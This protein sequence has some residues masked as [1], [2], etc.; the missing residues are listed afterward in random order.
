MMDQ[1]RRLPS[2][3]RRPHPQ[4]PTFLV[5]E[6]PVWWQPALTAAAGGR[7][8][9]TQQNISKN[10]CWVTIWM[11]GFLHLNHISLWVKTAPVTW[12]FHISTSLCESSVI[13]PTKPSPSW[14]QHKG[15]S[16]PRHHRRWLWHVKYCVKMGFS[17]L[18]REGVCGGGFGECYF[19]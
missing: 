7:V 19:V 18:M 9:V 3:A 4:V 8:P 6:E 11:W 1:G 17:S 13:R 2:P 16:W 15:S 10:K 5:R 14:E 12:C